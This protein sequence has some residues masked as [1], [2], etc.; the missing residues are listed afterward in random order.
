MQGSILM[1]ALMNPLEKAF[2]TNV[3]DI[4]NALRRVPQRPLHDGRLAFFQPLDVYS[5]ACTLWLV[6][7]AFGIFRKARELGDLVDNGRR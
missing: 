5:I 3:E 4:G 1:N 7:G 6:S 2:A